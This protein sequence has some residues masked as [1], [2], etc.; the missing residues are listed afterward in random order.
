MAIE[1]TSTSLAGLTVQIKEAALAKLLN[2][3]GILD[4]VRVRD[5]EGRGGNTVEFPIYTKVSSSQ[6]ADLS[7][8]T[9]Q[10]TNTLIQN[11]A[12]SATVTGH[13][14]V[15]PLT[16]L[17]VTDNDVDLV[18]EISTILASAMGRKLE[19]DVIGLFNGFGGDIVSGS[20]GSGSISTD[21]I[22]EGRRLIA[23]NDGDI[24]TM[25]MV[26]STKQTWGPKSIQSAIETGGAAM[27]PLN[28][29]LSVKG[30]V[31]NPF[32]IKW[33][34]SNEI[35]ETSEAKGLIFNPQAIGLHTKGLM[36]IE[37]QRDASNRLTEIVATGYWKAVELV[38]EWGYFVATDVS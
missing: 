31:P 1:T 38:D 6:V 11:A 17:A 23:A 4:V 26:A 32:N 8:G 33:L 28:D 3:A 5:T 2:Q 22:H 9:D 30:F 36:N 34:V 13:G 14:V 37:L 18:E 35:A 16:D 7:E 12:V 27:Q 24:N 10:T 20:A 15:V 29:E 19:S 21:M 25:V